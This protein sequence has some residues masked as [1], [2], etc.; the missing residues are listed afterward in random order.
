MAVVLET[1]H[2]GRRRR[3]K[4]TADLLVEACGD[5]SRHGALTIRTTLEPVE[6]AGSPVK[7]PTYPGDGGS[8][9]MIQID[10]RWIGEGDDRRKS[11]VVILDSVPSQAN[12]YES[13]LGEMAESLG[14]PQIVLDLSSVG[15]LPPHLP[16]QLTSYQFPHRN[17]D[18]Y[19]RDAELDGQSFPRTAIGRSILTATASSPDPLLQWCPQALLFGYWQSHVGKITQS[20][21]ARSWVSEL[22]GI[23]PAATDVR[24]TGVKGDPLNLSTDEKVYADESDPLTGWGFESEGRK[25]A[26]RLSELGHGQVLVVGTSRP[27]AGISFA[28][29]RQQSTVSFAS[30]RRINAESG[31]RSAAARA[32]LAAI[33]LVAHSRAFGRPFS[34]RSGCDLYPVR[35]DW[36]W[37]G[38]EGESVIEPPTHEEL[39]ELFR[40]CVGRA[41]AA[42]LPVG[43]YWASEPL[44]LTPNR[45][46]AEAIRRTWPESDD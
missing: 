27:P 10:Q 26:T 5:D 2:C 44:V 6:G 35:S 17:A 1:P 46:L 11:E 12:R 36:V 14:L 20:K 33:G 45:S 21:L 22:V 8:G 19:L 23:D 38:A 25:G 32:L 16:G 3:M 4:L 43:S 28:D 40:E 24:A 13:A 18:A 7:P 30:L 41:E 39:I 34:L 37:R 9:A 31:E 29:I 42:G 15:N